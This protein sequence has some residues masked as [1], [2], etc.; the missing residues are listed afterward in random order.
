MLKSLLKLD[1]YQAFRYN[2]L[3]FC[4][5]II[6]GIYILYILICTIKKINYYKPNNTILISLAIIVILFMIIRNIELFSYL[7]PT[8][9]YN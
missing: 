7:K 6:S 9:I 5:I 8:N 1:L 2:P 4:L 3:L